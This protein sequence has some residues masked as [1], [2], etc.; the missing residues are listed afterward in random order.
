MTLFVVGCGAA[1][2]STPN[3]TP[4]TTS[5]TPA[6]LPSANNPPAA[7]PSP[8]DT[9][10]DLLAEGTEFDGKV[11]KLTLPK[12]WVVKTDPIVA[13]HAVASAE[14][15]F[16]NVKVATLLPPTGATLAMVVA[17]SKKSYLNNGTIEEETEVSL[18]GT[19][20]HRMVLTQTLPGHVS[21][22]VKYFIPNGKRILIYSGQSSPDNFTGDLPIL[23]AIAKSLKVTSSP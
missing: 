2:P 5:A 11:F 10:P 22:Q 19:S 18:N 4:V 17:A 14:N 21:R 3:S 9:K 8:A 16:P 15:Q 13:L 20:A 7:T 23:D 12:G 1:G 6:T